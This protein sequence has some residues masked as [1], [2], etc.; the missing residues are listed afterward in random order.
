MGNR[1]ANSEYSESASSVTWEAANGMSLITT[2]RKRRSGRPHPILAVNVLVVFSEADAK[3]LAKKHPGM[4]FVRRTGRPE[5][6]LP[7]RSR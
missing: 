6:T 3:W 7:E 1:S 4:K 2:N 5:A